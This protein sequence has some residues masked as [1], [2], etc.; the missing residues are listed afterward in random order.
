MRREVQA[1]VNCLAAAERADRSEQARA[2]L[3]HQLL[4][5]QAQSVLV[6]APL[7]GELD[8]WPLALEA[9]AT[10]KKVALPRFNGATRRY[11]GCLIG[12]PERDLR[13]GHFGVREPLERCDS[14]PLNRLDFILVPGVAFDL[15]GRRL[16]R[17][18]GYYD[19]MLA[20]PHGATCGVGFDEQIVLQVPVAPH[21]ILLNCILTP[22]R[23]VEV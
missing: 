11:A 13:V 6:Y 19:Q 2:L 16:G 23:W 17:G 9:L 5:R 10:G 14:V 1:R 3:R 15:L 4:W 21:D 7:P 12:D 18:K 22:T 20:E 8:I